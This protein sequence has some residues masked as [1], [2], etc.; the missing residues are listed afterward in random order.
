MGRSCRHR[1]LIN[2]IM[3]LISYFI[4]VNKINKMVGDYP[5]TQRA[6][7]GGLIWPLI[8]LGIGVAL[9]VFLNKFSKM[10][11]S[12]VDTNDS[13]L[14]NEALGNLS[15]YFKFVGI[16]IIIVLVIFLLVFMFGLAMGLK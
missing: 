11:K 9:F 15:T 13:Y 16:L 1:L 5:G 8:S 2:S 3:G 10:A 14:I 4:Q 7:A 6:M 12:G